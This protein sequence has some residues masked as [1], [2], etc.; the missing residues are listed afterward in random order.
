MPHGAADLGLVPGRGR[1][2]SRAVRS[3]APRASRLRCFRARLA[4]VPGHHNSRTTARPSPGRRW[5]QTGSR[6][7]P[8]P[9][10]GAPIP[11]P[12]GGIRACREDAGALPPP[13][14]A[15]LVASPDPWPQPRPCPP[16][17]PHVAVL[18]GEVAARLAA[19]VLEVGEAA[20]VEEGSPL[21][22][23]G[24]LEG[25]HEAVV[26]AVVAGAHPTGLAHRG[27]L[28]GRDSRSPPICPGCTRPTRPG[29]ADPCDP[30]LTAWAVS[31]RA[32][33]LLARLP[34]STWCLVALLA[35]LPPATERLSYLPVSGPV[36]FLPLASSA[37]SLISTFPQFMEPTLLHASKRLPL[38]EAGRC[39]T[40]LPS[41]QMRPKV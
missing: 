20:A 13:G 27:R 35:L 7:G 34:L 6:Q 11:S 39:G 28:R 19:A 8:H 40:D 38:K 31:R 41:R 25:L 14:V 17:A 32:P 33:L 4:L 24:A 30:E 1:E 2:E 22:A 9:P 29:L 10:L 18:V 26:E 15:R 37:C 3:V 5:P 36:H 12:R 16:E 21:A 23:P